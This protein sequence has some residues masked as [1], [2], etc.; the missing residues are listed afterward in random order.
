MF[1]LLDIF[2]TSKLV[3]LP[4]IASIDIADTRSP[5]IWFSA[6]DSKNNSIATHINTG[7]L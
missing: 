5:W 1:G 2:S 4:H 7:A 6:S 3:A